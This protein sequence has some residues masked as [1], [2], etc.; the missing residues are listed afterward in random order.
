MPSEVIIP[1][2]ITIIVLLIAVVAATGVLIQTSS[3]LVKALNE[4]A[5][6]S[7]RRNSFV[8]IV[9][10]SLNITASETG[11]FHVEFYILVLN[12]GSEPL[13][14]MDST[15]LIVQY[16]TNLGTL[17][18]LYLKNRVNWEPVAVYLTANYS[19]PYSLKPVVDTGEYIAIRGSFDSDNIDAGKPVKVIFVS[20]YG[21]RDSR[22]V[23]NG[24]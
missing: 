11:G 8:E 19:I 5:E 24:S 20:Q 1:G 3:M 14:D 15:D 18:T 12:K 13:Y 2:F 21:A 16:F 4:Q 9:D 7:M 6:N 10:A 23:S 22:W 17:E